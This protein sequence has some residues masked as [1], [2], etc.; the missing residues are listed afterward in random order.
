[1]EL[2]PKAVI[3]LFRL[4][5]FSFSKSQFEIKIGENY[6]SDNLIIL[7]LKDSNSIVKGRVEMLNFVDY[8]SGRLLNPG[9]MG[10]YRFLPFMEC[11]HGV[12]SLTHNL[13]GKIIVDNKIFAFENG[14]GYIE[15]D[16]GTSMPSS[17]IWIQSNNF[18]NPNASFML[19]I[20]D[21][22]WI[23]KSFNGFLGFFYHDGLIHH[24][25]TYRS[26]KLY[27]EVS[28]NNSADIKIENRKNA[29]M[30]KAISNNT[31]MLKAPVEGDMD[32]RIAESID[33]TLLIS[34]LDKKGN[35]LF[36]NSTNITGLEMVGDFN[37]LQGLLK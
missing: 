15:K 23:G 20:A 26:T 10:W 28:G 35:I 2:L 14:K 33:A 1:M 24:F 3:I 4:S 27:L 12:V 34:M 9:I 5:N 13:K 17:W 31:G 37:K 29:F 16:W 18:S 7:D 11:Y 30:I 6:F 21:I 22:P 36:Q 25:S 32:R 19:S 8:S